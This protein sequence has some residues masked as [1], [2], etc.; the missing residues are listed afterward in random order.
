MSHEEQVGLTISFLEKTLEIKGCDNRFSCPR[1]RDY[2]VCAIGH[3]RNV[4]IRVPP[5][6]ALGRHGGE[7]PK[8]T[9]RRSLP[10]SRMSQSFTKYG[11]LPRIKWEEFSAIPVGLKFRNE[12]FQDVGHVL[13]GDLKVPLESTVVIAACDMFAEPM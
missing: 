9:G 4:L 11:R 10:I 2:Q 7:G 5:K 3:A 8:K 1:G 12:L 6:Y 13:S